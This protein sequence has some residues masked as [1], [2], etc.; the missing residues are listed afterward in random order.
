LRKPW[1]I[2]TTVR[3]PERLR[4]FLQVLKRLEGQEFPPEN[5]VKYQV[6][7]IQAK[8]YKPTML[9][10]IYKNLFNDPNPNSISYEQAQAIFNIKEYEDPPMRGRQSVNPLNKLGF[11]IARAG[12]GP[13]RITELGNK[14]LAGDYDISSIFFKSLLKL[15][16]P[17]PWSDDFSAQHGFNIMPFVA[18]LHLLHRLN[19]QSGSR[20]LDKR[21]FSIFIP[22][23]IS[24]DQI[25]QQIEKIIDFRKARNKEAFI[26]NFASQFYQVTPIPQKA[27]NNLFDYGDNTI[28][29]FRLTKYFK[30]IADPTGAHWHVDLEPSRIVEIEQLINAYDGKALEFDNLNAYLNYL[31]NITKPELPWEEITKLKEVATSWQKNINSTIADE[32]I[33][34]S[35]HDSKLFGIK[36]DTLSKTQLNKYISQLQDLNRALKDKIK[37]TRIV[38][39]I[40]KLTSIITALKDVRTLRKYSPEQ[41]EKLIADALLIINDEMKIQ[42]NYPV[43]DNGEPISHAPANKTDIECFYKSF[44]GICEVTL[45]CSK[46]QWVLE[47]QPVMRHLRDFEKERN[48]RNIF[49]LFIA[50]TIH[51]DTLSQ[52]WICVKYEYDGISQKIIPLTTSLFAKVLETLLELI[53]QNKRLSHKDMEIL[54]A[55]IVDESTHLPGFSQWAAFIPKALNQWQNTLLTS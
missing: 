32:K 52:F 14:F 51:N 49:C 48:D 39:D 17:N 33:T 29:Y 43:D 25:D 24:A 7:L 6:L 23:L 11:A 26:Q 45:N 35:P 8:V 54:Y 21:E 13:I 22:T 20:G 40:D 12:S 36:P 27:I 16:F 19:Q 15:Q 55:M 4:D 37:K 44:D 5:Q 28:R 41:F 3:N 2:S 50:P 30:V 47:G 46:L 38:N 42:P 18:S 1:S 53:K 10:E 31:S 34:I 9:P